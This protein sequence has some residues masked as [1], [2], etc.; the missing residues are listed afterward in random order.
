MVIGYGRGESTR[1]RP[2]VGRKPGVAMVVALTTGGGGG[3]PAGVD[4]VVVGAL[5]DQDYVGKAK[6]ARERYR[7]RRKIREEGTW[8]GYGAWLD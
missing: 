7:G 8:G 1:P 6:V 5:A 4:G 2:F 3:S